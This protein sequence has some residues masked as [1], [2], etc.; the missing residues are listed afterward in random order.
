[1][2][3]AGVTTVV[4]VWDPLYPILITREAT[5]QLYFPEWFIVGTGLSDT[6]AG[7]RLY[8]QSQWSHAFGVSPLWVP[9][10][11]TSVS[12]GYREYQHARPDDPPGS[13]GVLINIYNSRINTLFRGIH[14]A[15]PGL[16]QESF[17]AGLYAYPPTGGRA[18]NPLVFYT[19]QYPTEIKDFSE[20]W[21]DTSVSGPD[22]R[23]E[24]GQG[25][26]RRA[27]GG[28]R[29]QPGQWPTGP[30]SRA[31]GALLT[32]DTGHYAHEAD[33]HRHDPNQRCLSCTG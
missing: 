21:W 26:M 17:Q 23:G 10:Q 33:G 4:P 32:D 24:Q 8:D 13:G 11:T 30:P 3:N 12:A 27:D 20:V 31:N 29:Y 2:K 15:G 9:W 14:M 22:E 25:S 19:P 1:M 6:I 5:N 16:T 18:A 28:A 7:G